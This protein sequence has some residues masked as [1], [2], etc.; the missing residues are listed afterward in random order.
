MSV[1]ELRRAF[2]LSESIADRMRAFPQERLSAFGSLP[3]GVQAGPKITVLIAPVSAF[4]D[5][6][7]LDVR[8]ERRPRDVV[9]PIMKHS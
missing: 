4:V 7:D 6:L 2:V 8:V 1:D 5:P 3:F 9:R